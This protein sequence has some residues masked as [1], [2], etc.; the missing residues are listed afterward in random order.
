MNGAHSMLRYRP[1]SRIQRY[2]ISSERETASRQTADISGLRLLCR[3]ASGTELGCT[4]FDFANTPHTNLH[5]IYRLLY[6]LH[7]RDVDRRV[8][9]ASAL[10]DGV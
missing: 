8:Y 4:P 3:E 9:H 6:H 10:F 5:L 1:E 2:G 7:V